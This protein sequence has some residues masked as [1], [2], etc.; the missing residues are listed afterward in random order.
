M[1]AIGHALNGRGDGRVA[2]YNPALCHFLADFDDSK[3]ADP[4]L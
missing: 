1:F 2:E 4:S 3:Q